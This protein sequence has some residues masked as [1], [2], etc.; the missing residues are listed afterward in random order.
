[1]TPTPRP[2][3][4]SA[5]CC[6]V[7]A[8]T[9]WPQPDVASPR[10][11]FPR[12]L[13]ALAIIAATGVAALITVEADKGSVVYPVAVVRTPVAG[14]APERA[15]AASFTA[16][17]A[18]VSKLEV[19]STPNPPPDTPPATVQPN[20]TWEGFPLVVSVVE[21]S[22]DGLWMR[23]RLPMRPNGSNGWVHSSD[24][25]TWEVPN[26][27]EVSLGSHTLTVFRGGS[28]EVMFSVPVATGAPRTP[29]PV[30][31]FY[32]DIVNPIDHD[33][34]YGWGQLSVAGFSDVYRSFGGGI[35]QMALHGWND[36]SVVG[37]SVSNGCV[38]MRNDDIANLAPLAPLG[39]PVSVVA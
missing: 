7:P 16:G 11:R 25:R 3:G 5:T 20:P 14:A 12:L 27:V 38:R 6:T 24:L 37:R 29:T 2:G 31:D 9:G 13:L 26:R 36:P 39:T 34:L 21:K 19:F 28:G 22:D 18:N 15:P 33:P 35:G 17:E 8:V 23:V 10:W 30:G 4:S 32:I 1:M